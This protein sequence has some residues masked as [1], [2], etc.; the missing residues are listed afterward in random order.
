MASEPNPT[1]GAKNP[2]VHGS[3]EQESGSGPTPDPLHC[4]DY[5]KDVVLQDFSVALNISFDQLSP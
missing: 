5:I 3:L 1:A 2:V 4:F